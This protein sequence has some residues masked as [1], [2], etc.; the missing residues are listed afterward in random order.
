MKFFF[1]ESGNFQLPQ[2][3][4]HRVG[5]VSGIAIPDSDEAE[6]F[7]RFD[8]FLSK[9][10]SASFKD[11]EP[12]GRCLDDASRKA[13]ATM[14]SNLP[15]IVISPIM[16]DLTSLAGQPQAEVPTLVARKLKELEATCRHETLRNQ[17]AELALDVGKLSTQQA[18]RLTA[19]AKCVARTIQDSIILYGSRDHESSWN[20]LRFEIDPVEQ[21]AGNREER[22]F[23]T[24][25]PMWATSWSQDEPFTTIEG[26]HTA[27]HPL[28]KN[29]DTKEGLDIGKMFSNNVH[30]VSSASSRGIQLADMTAS[31]VKRAVIG[32]ANATDLQNYGLMM[33]KSLGKPQRACGLFCLAPATIDDLNR[34]YH[35]LTDAISGARGA[36]PGSYCEP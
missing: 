26:I 25:L 31:L 23:G 2:A 27:D 28:V 4:E 36:H 7:R 33:T 10:P 8:A 22:V 14:L 15:V 21:M 35:G 30:Y 6:I 3:G 17:I 5:I 13:L 19:W 16:L 29:W 18:L 20:S 11:G 32:I 1:D 9:L 24:M 34:R 12:K